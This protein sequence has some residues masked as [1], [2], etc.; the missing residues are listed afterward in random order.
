MLKQ[1]DWNE[2]KTHSKWEKIFP[3]ILL[4]KD[5]VLDLLWANNTEYSK[6]DWTLDF[7]KL[8][9]NIKKLI[10][11]TSTCDILSCL[12]WVNLDEKDLSTIL[13]NYLD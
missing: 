1:L 11:S 4:L 5:Y 10:Y 13:K 3:W 9:E 2:L 12:Q 8:P 6:Q 7:D